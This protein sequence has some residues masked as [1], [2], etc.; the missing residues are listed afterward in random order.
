MK[1][2]GLLACL[3][4][5]ATTAAVASAPQVVVV[6]GDFDF[7]RAPKG[8]LIEHPFVVKNQLATP[9][10]I[11]EVRLTPPLTLV[12]A[13]ASIAAGAQG[14]VRVRLDTS[15]INGQFEGRIAL[16]IANDDE[17]DITLTVSGTVYQTVEAVPR[18]A[19]FVV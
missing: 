16:S 3:L 18:P 5:A 19:F 4:V 15:K 6:D 13:P 17:P 7:G 10:V 11:D 2:L 9:L 14:I 1:G 8:A 12:G